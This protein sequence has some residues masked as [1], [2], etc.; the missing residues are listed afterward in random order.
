MAHVP[1]TDS[2]AVPGVRTDKHKRSSSLNSSVYI[3]ALAES[4]SKSK[5]VS[6]QRNKNKNT[7]DAIALNSADV[8]IDAV[9]A[10]PPLTHT[11]QQVCDITHDTRS[12]AML[13][14]P[15]MNASGLSHS[16]AAYSG[17]P[18]SADGPRHSHSSVD[19]VPGPAACVSVVVAHLPAGTPARKRKQVNIS[20]DVE[21]S[22]SEDE[23]SN[24]SKTIPKNSSKRNRGSTNSSDDSSEKNEPKKGHKKSNQN[25]SSWADRALLGSADLLRVSDTMDCTPPIH[26]VQRKNHTE[27]NKKNVVYLA[28]KEKNI[29]IVNYLRH[30]QAGFEK[31]FVAAY[32]QPELLKPI[33]RR[34]S[35]L[36]VCTDLAQKNQLLKA[37]AIGDLDIIASL[38]QSEMQP[39]QSAQ[40]LKSFVIKGVSDDFTDFFIQNQTKANSVKRYL[41]RDENGDL[42]PTSTVQLDFSHDYQPP[43]AVRIGAAQYKMFDYIPRPMQCRRCFQFGHTEKF[44]RQAN[45]NCAFCASPSHDIANCNKKAQK[46]ICKNCK[47]NHE[48]NSKSCPVYKET[49]Q[50]LV[51]RVKEGK[52]FAQAVGVVRSRNN[53]SVANMKSITDGTTHPATTSSASHVQQQLAVTTSEYTNAIHSSSSRLRTRAARNK[54]T[55]TPHPTPLIAKPTTVMQAPALVARKAPPP[56]LKLHGAPA[57]A[58]AVPTLSLSQLNEVYKYIAQL[59]V[60]LIYL[61][62]RLDDSDGETRGVHLKSITTLMLSISQQI[63]APIH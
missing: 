12:P 10:I 44:C 34:N 19:R 16:N 61:L 55:S 59:S 31:H 48:A 13:T 6:T 56:V 60:T 4:I 29:K 33:A 24:H 45:S 9:S 2:V 32:G 18:S 52:T 21:P 23:Y 11:L 39:V 1:S 63:N 41:K 8:L 22:S 46:P 37:T 38:P 49:E 7:T 3:L 54:Q 35:L 43:H 53:V 15:V 47:G 57:A 26:D 25:S 42:I 51:V 30:N 17:I 36:V 14:T 28:A 40:K 58:S 50:A 62:A 5:R 27:S 20:S